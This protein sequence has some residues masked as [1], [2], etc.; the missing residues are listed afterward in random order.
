MRKYRWRRSVP[1]GPPEVAPDLV[2]VDVGEETLHVDLAVQRH[3][4]GKAVVGDGDLDVGAGRL[5]D[6]IGEQAREA[7][8]EPPA[9]A[10]VDV[11]VP[12]V[13]VVVQRLLDDE[14]LVGRQRV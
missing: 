6:A 5:G 4:E 11:V 1:G 9:V 7:V 8:V 12:F 14:A 13:L 10:R 2:R 3:R